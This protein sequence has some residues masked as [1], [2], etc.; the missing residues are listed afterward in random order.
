M[1]WIVNECQCYIHSVK[2]LIAKS[3]GHLECE[4]GRKELQLF[5][6]QPGRPTFDK[7]MWYCALVHL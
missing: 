7:T 6:T 4:N 3:Y 2:L 1:L 5:R